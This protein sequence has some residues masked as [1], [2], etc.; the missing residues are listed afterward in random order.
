[1]L[2]EVLA[3]LRVARSLEFALGLAAAMRE[4]IFGRT[5]LVAQPFGLLTR[6]TKLDDVTHPE[7]DDHRAS[8]S[9]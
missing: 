1:M 3:G 5:L 9:V 4:P 2:I 8:E 6:L 7:L